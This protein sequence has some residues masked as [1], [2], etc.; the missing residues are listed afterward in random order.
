M[1]LGVGTKARGDAPHPNHMHCRISKDYEL[2]VNK[3]ARAIGKGRGWKKGSI[4]RKTSGTCV[5]DCPKATVA[6]GF[7]LTM[8]NRWVDWEA[9]V[10]LY[11]GLLSD[12]VD[13]SVVQGVWVVGVGVGIL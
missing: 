7:G 8:R 6:H 13:H 12:R 9:Q 2:Y 4:K 11:V 5:H 10:E 3:M 1:W